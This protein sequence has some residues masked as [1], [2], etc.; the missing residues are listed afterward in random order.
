MFQVLDNKII[1]SMYEDYKLFK[2]LDDLLKQTRALTFTCER[3]S[4][5]VMSFK[6]I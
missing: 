1:L 3:I 2:T 4:D 6:N 5:R